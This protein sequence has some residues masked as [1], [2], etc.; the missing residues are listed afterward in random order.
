MTTDRSFIGRRILVAPAGTTLSLNDNRESYYFGER[1][2]GT[3]VGICCDGRP[4]VQLDH[5]AQAETHRG[6]VS[7]SEIHLDR[8]YLTRDALEAPTPLADDLKELADIVDRLDKSHKSLLS[9]ANRIDS[10]LYAMENRTPWW[11][12]VF[13][14]RKR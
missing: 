11:R 6:T 4:V 14:W 10:R 12:R 7:L 8:A 1:T 2:E 13:R 3:I 5:A 9:F